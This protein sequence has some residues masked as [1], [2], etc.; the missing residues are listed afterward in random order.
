MSLQSQK[1]TPYAVQAAPCTSSVRRGRAADSGSM[2][3]AVTVHD[4]PLAQAP[5]G[6]GGGGG[7]G[8][9]PDAEVRGRHLPA[10]QQRGALRLPP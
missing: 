7:G 2:L 10:P 9:V 4:V 3:T 8:L 6:G 1:H 5:D